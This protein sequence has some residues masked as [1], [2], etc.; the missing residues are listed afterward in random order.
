MCVGVCVG[1]CGVRGWVCVGVCE[2]VCGC[3]RVVCGVCGCVLGFVWVWVCGCV[4]V[5]VCVRCVW[6]C[7]GVC[8]R[9]CVCELGH[10]CT[11]AAA[12]LTSWAE[13]LKAAC[14]EICGSVFGRLSAKR[15]PQTSLERRGS[16]CS[17]GCT[18]TQP[19]RPIL[20]TCRGD[21][22]IRRVAS[23]GSRSVVAKCV[24]EAWGTKATNT[25]T[26]G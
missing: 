24:W 11:D 26:F 15:G 20:K 8:V 22:N 3:V 23:Y 14:P 1:V 21:K 10:R 16:Y 9:G 4:C 12:W 19:R 18:K 6:V 5:G 13:Y 25:T 7:V 2:C 17:A